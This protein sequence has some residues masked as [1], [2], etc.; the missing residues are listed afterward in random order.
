MTMIPKLHESTISRLIEQALFEDLGFGDVTSESIIA[1]D[2]LATAHIITNDAGVVAGLEVAGL[3]Y[4]YIDMQIT[5]SSLVREGTDIKS[6]Q[7]V[8]HI[9]GPLRGIIQGKQTSLNFI[10]RMSGIASLTSQYVNKIKDTKAKITGSRFTIPTLRMIDHLALKTGGGIVRSFGVDEEIVITSDHS[11]AAGGVKQAIMKALEYL[12][13]QEIYNKPLG[14][15]VRTFD[16]LRDI[17]GYIDRLQRIV[18]VN[19][20]PSVI[21][22]A[23]IAITE[24][25]KI[26]ARGGITLENVREVAEAGVDY[27]CIPD[28]T[29]SPRALN[30]DLRVSS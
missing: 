12:E 25:T 30:F 17:L 29:H 8:V 20:H 4:R 3:V 6:G 13:R 14:I 26:E 10:M 2:S 11:L 24:K 18:L 28:L 9:H 15:E 19:F 22:Q 21:P 16:E 23:V 7:T 5:C 27:I 1:E